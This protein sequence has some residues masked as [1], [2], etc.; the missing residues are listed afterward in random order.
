MYYSPITSFGAAAYYL[1]SWLVAV[2]VVI[3]LNRVSSGV[4]KDPKNV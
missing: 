2:D 4:Q 1:A 3:K